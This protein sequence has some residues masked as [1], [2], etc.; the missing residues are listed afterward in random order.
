MLKRVENWFICVFFWKKNGYK[1][2]MIGVD[3]WMVYGKYIN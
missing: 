3:G 1:N 2:C